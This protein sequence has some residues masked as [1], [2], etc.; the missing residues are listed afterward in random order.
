MDMSKSYILQITTGVLVVVVIL[1]V[2][3]LHHPN[4]VESDDCDIGNVCMRG[5]LTGS[6]TEGH[7]EFFPRPA[8]APCTSACYVADTELY[9]DGARGECIGTDQTTCKG[10]CNVSEDG[11]I[12]GYGADICNA[13][14]LFPLW[15]YFKT[16][17]YIEDLP[18][19]EFDTDSACFAN[20][21][22]MIALQTV[23][24]YMTATSYQAVSSGGATECIEMIDSTLVDTSCI[25][26]KEYF[27]ETAD[28]STLM[29][30]KGTT[31]ATNLTGR[32]CIFSYACSTPNTTAFSDEAF[33]DEASVPV[34]SFKRDVTKAHQEVPVRD[35]RKTL[36]KKMLEKNARSQTNSKQ[37]AI[38]LRP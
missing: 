28:L 1:L 32:L 36:M 7:C 5:L 21:C 33:L 23:T 38:T 13:S 14:A 17:L 15:P 3:L 16:P 19:L 29:E 25:K 6:E 2:A 37:K 27:V 31:Y 18:I 11:D 34:A 4:P 8:S 20:Q 24:T 12:Y 10:W 22:V 35:E 26:T 30:D 9:C